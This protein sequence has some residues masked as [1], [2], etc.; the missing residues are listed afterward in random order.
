MAAMANSA[1][2]AMPSTAPSS[3]M[4]SAAA[5]FGQDMISTPAVAM[6]MASAMP[7]VR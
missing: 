7:N 5:C 2:E 6:M 4:A 1:P 3:D